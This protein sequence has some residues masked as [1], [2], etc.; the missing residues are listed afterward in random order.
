MLPFPA[1]GPTAIICNLNPCIA[2]TPVMK[3]TERYARIQFESASHLDCV[4]DCLRLFPCKWQSISVDQD[5]LRVWLDSPSENEA[6]RHCSELR[7]ERFRFI[8]HRINALFGYHDGCKIPVFVA[9]QNIE[10]SFAS[11]L[12]IF[13]GVKPAQPF[14]MA[15]FDQR[16][17]QRRKLISHLS[18][19]IG[20]C[21]CEYVIPAT[22]RR[23]IEIA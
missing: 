9:G 5:G 16:K 2:L 1:D 19:F 21:A 20:P 12:W 14:S 6:K 8:Q 10:N 11:R 13:A 18:G 23:K 3:H 17:S 7:I 15:L 4:F 22:R